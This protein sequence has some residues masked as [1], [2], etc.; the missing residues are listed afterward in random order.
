MIDRD[1]DGKVSRREY[2]QYMARTIGKQA[3]LKT[4]TEKMQPATP[5]TF[6]DYAYGEHEKQR[7]D[8]WVAGADG[9]NTPLVIYIHGGGFKGGDKAAVNGPLIGK[10]LEKGIAFASMNYRLTDVGPYPMQMH[11]CARGLQTIRQQAEKFHIDPKRIA[12]MGGSAGSG[13]SQWLA[14]HEDLADPK[15]DDPISRQST[16]VSC[17]VPYA[18]QCSYDPRFI[19]ELFD[20]DALHEALFAFYGMKSEEDINNPK[21]FPLFEDASPVTHL[22]ADDPPIFLY[23]GQPDKP[24]PKNSSGKEHIHHP[25]FGHYL[26]EKMDSM[27]IECTLRLR[28]D[29]PAFPNDEVIEFFIRHLKD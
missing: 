13:I 21:F 28:E 2:T 25:K 5:P 4:A 17:A 19:A 6:R 24:L 29:T 27:G 12:L 10:L 9:T 20:S 15:S 8:L 23:Y 7:F 1:K 16:R 11:D 22:T 18:A 26:K 3:A 14:F